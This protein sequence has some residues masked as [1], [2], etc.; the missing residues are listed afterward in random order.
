MLRACVI[1]YDKHWDKCL[2]LAEFSYNNSYQSNLKMSPFEALYGCQCRTPLNWSQT[3]ECEIFGP[4]L[5]T[6]A[7]EKVKIIQNNL[8]IAQST[9]KSYADKKEETNTV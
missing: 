7:E 2:A 6:K 1:Q 9:Q 4:E 3:G 8:K 5:V